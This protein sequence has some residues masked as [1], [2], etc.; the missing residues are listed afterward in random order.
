MPSLSSATLPLDVNLFL[1]PH[2]HDNE[3]DITAIYNNGEYNLDL[4][5]KYNERSVLNLTSMNLANLGGGGEGRLG[6]GR[7]NWEG[8]EGC[9]KVNGEM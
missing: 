6:M 4:C 5:H 7:S 8:A 9:G 1:I 2:F 3:T